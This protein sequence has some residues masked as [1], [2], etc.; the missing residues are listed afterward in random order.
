[1]NDARAADTAR[2]L[3]DPTVLLDCLIVRLGNR[4]TDGRPT[5]RGGQLRT[6]YERVSDDTLRSAFRTSV[7]NKA[8]RV[9]TT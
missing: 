8:P 7:G 4:G 2:R 3:A 6:S 1:M 9:F 5:R